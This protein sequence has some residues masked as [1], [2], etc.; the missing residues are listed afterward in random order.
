MVQWTV[1]L[2]RRIP[3]EKLARVSAYDAL[4]S[5]MAM[6]VGALI[7]G[8]IAGLVGV[9]ATQYG[10]AALIV[11]ASALT[12]IPRDVRRMR[13]DWSSAAQ[14]P[15]AQLAGIPLSVPDGADREETFAATAR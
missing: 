11:V 1:A 3:P 14:L 5:V 12:L 9:P 2:A 4:G 15:A 10:A 8:P 6:P 13:S 7:A